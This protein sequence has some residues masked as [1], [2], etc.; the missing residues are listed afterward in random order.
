MSNI[1]INIRDKLPQCEPVTLLCGNSDYR[2]VWELDEEWAPYDSKTMRV[3]LADGTYQDV[4][5]QGQEAALPVLN[6]PGWI[7]VGLYAG[8]VHTSRGVELR[9][10]PAITTAGG[11]PAAPAEDVYAQLTEQLSILGTGVVGPQGPKGDKGDTGATGAKG[12]KGD[13]GATGPQGPKGDKGEKGDPGEVT[14]PEYIQA[15]ALRVAKAAM[16]ITGKPEATPPAPAYTNQLPISTDA[17][18][19]VFN[20]VGYQDGYRFNSSGVA[21]AASGY[22]ISGFIPCAVYDVIRL[23]GV[24]LQANSMHRVSY[25]DSNKNCLGVASGQSLSGY[26]GTGN[27]AIDSDTGYYTQF[28]ISA[29]Y[30]NYASIAYIRIGGQGFDPDAII[31]VNEEIA[32][33]EGSDAGAPQPQ[34]RFAFLSD[35]HCGYYTDTEN[36]AVKD[37]GLAIDE[38]QKH[39][40]LD[41]VVVGG[42]YSTGALT[43]TAST[44]ADDFMN[45]K[46]LLKP[47]IGATPSLW[48][49]GNHDDAPY[50]GTS[51]RLDKFA[52]FAQIG[53]ES[54]ATRDVVTDPAAP[55]GAY[56]YLDFPAQRIR[57]IYLNTDDKDQFDIGDASSSSDVSYLNAHH[58][59]A[60]QLAWLKATALDLSGKTDES[61]W[62]IVV[63]SHC[64]LN[65]S[66]SYVYNGATYSYSTATAA[67]ALQDYAGQ[68][69][70]LF[71]I[72]GHVHNINNGTYGSIPYI[73]CPNVMNGRER[74]SADG[75]TYSK[76]A[77]TA[78]GTALTVVVLDRAN[79]KVHA[80][81]YGAGYDQT[82][83]VP[84]PAWS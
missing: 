32:E 8:D 53:C 15:E 26:S 1:H 16:A 56:G 40:Q 20:A 78:T 76:T 49:K 44:T 77:G 84:T 2:I 25:Y 69:K 41:A 50:K 24:N 23:Q 11:V 79:A 57:L 63:A 54:L 28:K 43:S 72:N 75:Q 39:L 6:V 47:H 4:L 27:Y 45:C 7:S 29:S 61:S 33:T 59:G 52:F 10:L 19:A 70:V 34:F 18:G 38:L 51:G 71:C 30:S 22:S 60:A 66:G 48:L 3:C 35:M 82:V 81:H 12:D 73:Q 21:Q 65:I 13:T 68:A 83:S 55:Q 5:F 42:D 31:T 64:P 67:A 9:V 74:A 17:D 80:V 62:G 36:A 14:V 58:I 37:A 46:K